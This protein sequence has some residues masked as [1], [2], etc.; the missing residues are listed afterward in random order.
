[1]AVMEPK[2]KK[3]SGVKYWD[4]AYT[5]AAGKRRWKRMYSLE[6]AT[7]F[8]ERNNIPKPRAYKPREYKASRVPS[9]TQSTSVWETREPTTSR[10]CFFN[11]Q[12][13]DIYHLEP[14]RTGA[15]IKK[16]G[17]AHKDAKVQLWPWCQSCWN[18]SKSGDYGKT[19]VLESPGMANAAR[20]IVSTGLSGQNAA[21]SSHAA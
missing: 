3:I 14:R 17:I 16:D 19:G 2:Y 4:V 9:K 11:C 21:P 6:S 18:R 5:T 8:F 10:C 12:C 15:I 1:M 20:Q 13:R 7:V